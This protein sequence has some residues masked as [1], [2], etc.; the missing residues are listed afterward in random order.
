M[1][2]EELKKRI[3]SL[4]DA[5]L[6]ELLKLRDSYQSEAVEF[7]VQEALKRQ[8]IESEAD[9]Q[10]TRFQPEHRDTKTIFPHLNN[11]KQFQKVFNSL[12]RVLY[13]VAIIPLVFGALKL[14][15]ADVRDGLVLLGLGLLWVGLSVRLQKRQHA[16]TP[17][18]LM[19]LL[20]FGLT[21]VFFSLKDPSALQVTDLIVFGIATLLLIYVLIYI[22]VLLVRKKNNECHS[23]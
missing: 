19:V 14:I 17:L 9:L 8:I 13:L 22:R 3:S 12:I 11:E 6:I 10:S 5:K 7:A 15:E 16:H 20:L 21:R 2:N 18:A 23:D 1:E 4:G